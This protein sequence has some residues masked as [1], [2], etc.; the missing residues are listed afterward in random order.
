MDEPGPIFAIDR[1]EHQLNAIRQKLF[2]FCVDGI[3]HASETADRLAFTRCL[4]RQAG[5]TVRADFS[6]GLQQI[7]LRRR[8][9]NPFDLVLAGSALIGSGNNGMKMTQT[10]PFAQ[11]PL[12][13]TSA[14]RARIVDSKIKGHRDW[15]AVSRVQL[16]V[17]RHA[18]N[19]ATGVSRVAT[20]T[21]M[22]DNF[23]D[24]RERNL[25]DL[26]VS[27][28]NLNAGT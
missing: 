27:T 12:R 19:L 22:I 11:M 21:I 18:T 10:S 7:D 14:Q 24:G 17:R 25:H 26:T 2:E 6:F 3:I 5:G 23:D 13:I 20:R 1:V 8:V 4:K 9:F 15:L 16:A 28:L